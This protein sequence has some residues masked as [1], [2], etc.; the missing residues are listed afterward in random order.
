MDAKSWGDYNARLEERLNADGLDLRKHAD[1]H[2][3]RLILK[4]GPQGTYYLV[5]VNEFSGKFDVMFRL[6]HRGGPTVYEFLK[7]LDPDG[8]AYVTIVGSTQ[9]V[10]PPPPLYYS[11]IRGAANWTNTAST[12]TSNAVQNGLA[13]LILM[14]GIVMVA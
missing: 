9:A 13:I 1:Q 6:S 8:A 3:V 11:S 4:E 2:P 10:T 14:V 5:N 7:T 12:L